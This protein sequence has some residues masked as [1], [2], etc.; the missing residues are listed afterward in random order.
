MKRCEFV[1]FAVEHTGMLVSV[2][3][4]CAKFIAAAPDPIYLGI[5]EHQH[6]C[7]EGLKKPP[8]SVVGTAARMMS[9]SLATDQHPHE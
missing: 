5:V 4:V 9:N 7:P 6:L 1:R 8:R 3:P 2:C